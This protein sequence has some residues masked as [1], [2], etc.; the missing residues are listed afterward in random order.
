MPQSDITRR[1]FVNGVLIATGSAAV[2]RP[3]H[4]AASDGICDGAIGRDPRV[5][6][7]GNLPSTFDIAHWLRDRR[8]SFAPRSVTLA[9]GCDAFAS[10][11][12]IVE[13]E[14]HFDVAIVGGGLAGLS[15]AFHLLRRRPR[16]KLL[17]IEA[18]PRLGGNAGRDDAPPLPGPAS[19][20]GAYG[21]TPATE[22][23][24]EFY[25]EIGVD[26][27]A[28]RIADPV[29]NYFF[30]AHTPGAQPGHSGW[31]IDTFE[32]GLSRA[33]YE[34]RILDDLLR[35]REA[36]LA[37]GSGLADP[38][39]ESPEA[40]D[41][42][43]TISLQRYLEQTLRCDP[44]VTAFYTT[45]TLTALGGA[46]HQVN[47]HTAL[48]FLASEFTHRGIFTFPGGTSG[49]ALLARRWLMGAK[50][51]G[52]RAPRIE[53]NAIVLRIEPKRSS[54]AGAS[55]V[56]F[57]DRTFRRVAAEKII[58][59]APPQSARHL[60]EDLADAPRR[61]AWAAFHTAPLVTA[62]VVLRSAA[63]LLELGLGYSQTWWGGRYF[64]NFIVADW[65][66]ERRGVAE[67]QTTLTFYGGCDAPLEEL[68]AERLKLLHTPFAAYEDALRSDFGRLL[69]GARFDFDRDV[70]AIFLY[71][72]GHSMLRP[73]PSWLFG[74][75]RGR[76]GRLDRSRAPRRIACAPLGPVLFAG[77][78]VEGAPSVES[79]IGSGR[80]AAL[81]AL[82][83]L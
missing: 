29:N 79:A 76:D 50:A 62:N 78:H 69:R 22:Q 13:D 10:H 52:G 49:L 35:S 82:A 66:G 15:A 44:A 53:V 80:R 30:D 3:L 61:E 21:A 32:A 26:W 46:A 39:D 16:L 60:A 24:R 70:S 4:A 54:R 73:P 25:R 27:E 72:W 14:Q 45:Y 6:R 28:R 41:H 33:P 42:L 51:R 7:G 71:R 9:P 23:L 2:G 58:V 55:V 34:K 77:Q 8:L 59:A 5:L 67:R 48:S 43:S 83:E 68:G 75:V 74:D 36:I 63:P 20:A 19:T 64:D 31:N 65:A 17:L 40:L 18:G 11:F 47:A 38:A 56:Y 1:D 37:Q 81:Q 57:Q 12:P